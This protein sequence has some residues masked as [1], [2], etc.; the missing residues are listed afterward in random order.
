MSDDLT[1]A[2]L[3]AIWIR[4]ELEEPDYVEMWKIPTTVRHM[5]P[6]ATDER[7]QTISEAVLKALVTSGVDVGDL[8]G[9]TGVFH[10][11]DT[12]QPVAR[13]LC[14]WAALGRDPHAEY[15]RE[16]Q[17]YACEITEAGLLTVEHA[18]GDVAVPACAAA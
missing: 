1:A 4:L 3:T 17:L 13:V 5:L 9:N 6:D 7:V 16:R 14:E 15:E 18:D 8:D 10:P 11:W 2:A 12:D